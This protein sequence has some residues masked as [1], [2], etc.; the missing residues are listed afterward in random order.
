MISPIDISSYALGPIVNEVELA[1]VLSARSS[2]CLV[3]GISARRW[4]F[5][6]HYL[7]RLY[8]F[9]QLNCN[10]IV[11]PLLNRR[12]LDILGGFIFAALSF[13]TLLMI[14][15]RSGVDSVF[16]R[17][18][19]VAPVMAFGC[20][21]LRIP[22]FYRG[23]SVPFNVAE[24]GV[25]HFS[26]LLRRIRETL[27][28][29]CD[30]TAITKVTAV[31]VSSP[32]AADIVKAYAPGKKT[33]FFPY[34]IPDIFFCQATSKPGSD[35]ITLNYS[36]SLNKFYDFAGLLEA[37]RDLGAEG[38][39][40]ALHICGDGPLKEEILR[41]SMRLHASKIVEIHKEVA[42]GRVPE[43]VRSGSA[44]VIPYSE[45]VQMGLSLKSMEAMALGVPVIVS[46]RTDSLY[47]DQWNCIML[48]GSS[49][50]EW[51]RAIRE[52]A[53]S[54]MSQRVIEGG[55][56]TASMFRREKVAA[57]FDELIKESSRLRNTV[58]VEEQQCV[59]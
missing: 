15:K 2:L 12:Y 48:H 4:Y 6:E 55:S 38:M 7:Q 25:G 45:E 44:V 36:G 37:I 22:L 57:I 10:V 32:G 59:T 13:L 47:I 17:G 56:K 50:Q 19:F 31:L 24:I 58:A 52:A 39:P 16:M 28:R 35:K 21:F 40:V 3:V 27:Q 29:F 43:I 54:Q 42:R 23:L 9:R 20:S 8:R 33:V 49:V 30:H 5:T 51:K 34:V 46:K 11:I 18:S 26:G 41:Q 1:S 14:R 53:T